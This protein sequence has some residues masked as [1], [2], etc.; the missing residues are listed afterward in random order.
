MDLFGTPRSRRDF[1]ATSGALTV[2]AGLLSLTGCRDAAGSAAEA[3]RNG[4]GPRVLT[5]GERRTLDA[6]SDRILPPDGASPGA[7]AMGAVVFI[8]HYAAAH[9]D[10]LPGLRAATA[11]LDARATALRPG[12]QGFA[13]LDQGAAEELL[14]AMSKEAP[15]DFQLLHL[16]V[17]AGAFAAPARGGNL[18]EAGW[19]LLGYQDQHSWQPPFGFYDEEAAR[20]ATA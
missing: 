13:A 15:A 12:V 6:L 4:A 19:T 20:G 17:V 11:A 16:S 9:A 14:A 18:D 10:F 5:D 1:L 7:A 8:D 2:G 3:M